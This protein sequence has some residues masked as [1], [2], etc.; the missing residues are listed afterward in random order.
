[1]APRDQSRV[2]NAEGK[3]VA[4]DCSGPTAEQIDKEVRKLSDDAYQLARTTLMAYRGKLESIAKALLQYEALDGSQIEE[5]IKH[6]R[7]I[8]PV[9][10]GAPPSNKKAGVGKPLGLLGLTARE[11][12]VLAWV[13]QGK[14]NYEIGVILTAGTRTICK[15]VERILTKLGVE[16]RTAA[17][18]IAIAALASTRKISD[19]VR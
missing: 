3:A 9:P 11:T 19:L 13:A 17:A 4:R 10:G 2:S 14:T 5:I 7:L 15:H 18:A 6:G 16:N 1:M 8:R 12:E